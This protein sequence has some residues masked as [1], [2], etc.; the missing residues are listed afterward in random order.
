MSSSLGFT[1]QCK[2]CHKEEV[3]SARP[4]LETEMDT[5]L[6]VEKEY[7]KCIAELLKKG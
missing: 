7:M 5:E 1:F 3:V 2:N 4:F 6:N